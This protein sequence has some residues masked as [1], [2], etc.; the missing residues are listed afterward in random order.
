MWRVLGGLGVVSVLAEAV[1]A[2]PQTSAGPKMA[3]VRIF[4]IANLPKIG[5]R[6]IFRGIFENE[7]DRRNRQ[8]CVAKRV[9]SGSI[10]CDI[11]IK[12]QHAFAT[13]DC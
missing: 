4:N 11:L 6:P 5:V 13:T 7:I 3:T 12:Q 9:A 10:F 8:A 2:T 1:A